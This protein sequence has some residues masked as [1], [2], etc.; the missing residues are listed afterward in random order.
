MAGS[1]LLRF[2]DILFRIMTMRY[3]SHSIYKIVLTFLK[4]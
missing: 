4:R 3:L 1:F 2:L